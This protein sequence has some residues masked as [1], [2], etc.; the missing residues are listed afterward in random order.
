[1][2]DSIKLNNMLKGSKHRLKLFRQD[3]VQELEE[4]VTEKDGKYRDTTNLTDP[5][6]LVIKEVIEA[7][8]K[9]RNKLFHGELVP[10]EHAKP[11][12]QHAYLIMIMLF[13]KLV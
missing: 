9:L 3:E 13:P 4:R 6:H 11:V 1:M 12:Y 10:D 2:D 7:L 8:Y 5:G